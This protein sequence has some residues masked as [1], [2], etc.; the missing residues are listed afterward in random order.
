MPVNGRGGP[1]VPARE[2]ERELGR[3]LVMVLLSLTLLTACAVVRGALVVAEEF[4]HGGELTELSTRFAVLALVE[5]IVSLGLLAV[6]WS[7]RLWGVHAHL[8]VKVA[9][10]LLTSLAARRFVPLSVVPTLLAVLLWVAAYEAGW[11]PRE[12]HW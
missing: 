8:A 9:M 5:S 7:R 1:R 11:R 12:P 6:A 2:D 10:V 3:P 4:R